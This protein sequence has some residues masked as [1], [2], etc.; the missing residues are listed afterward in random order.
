LESQHYGRI[1]HQFESEL[2]RVKRNTERNREQLE[3]LRE[4]HRERV[5]SRYRNTFE[6]IERDEGE[7]TALVTNVTKEE[8]K[9]FE[10]FSNDQAEQQR[11]Y[12]RLADRYQQKKYEIEIEGERLNDVLEDL[13]GIKTKQGT[14]RDATNRLQNEIDGIRRKSDD[15]IKSIEEIRRRISLLP[16]EFEQRGRGINIKYEK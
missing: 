7:L 12:R 10:D 4:E 11:Y 15:T 5:Y 9:L 8:G 6:Q 3:R 2:S 1:E 13:R 16:A 14:V